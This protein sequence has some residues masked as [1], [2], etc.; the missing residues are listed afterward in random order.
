MTD[1]GF[2]NSKPEI[3]RVSFTKAGFITLFLTDGRMLSAPLERFPGIASL[4]PVQRR[5]YHI[6]DDTILLFRDDDEVYHIQDFLGT[7]ETNAYQSPGRK[8][9]RELE[10]A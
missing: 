10:N 3:D 6:A 4:S 2:N 5:Q 7:Y 9:P 1:I 8:Q